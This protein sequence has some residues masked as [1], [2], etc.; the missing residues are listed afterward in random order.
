MNTEDMGSQWEGN[1]ALIH[2]VLR[3]YLQVDADTVRP[4]FRS[5]VK[6]K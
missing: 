3:K 1:L 6:P 4:L 5:P 2:D